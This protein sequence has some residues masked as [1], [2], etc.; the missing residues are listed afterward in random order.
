MTA[1]KTGRRKKKEKIIISLLIYRLYNTAHGIFYCGRFERSEMVMRYTIIV[2]I[3]MHSRGVSSIKGIP[4]VVQ[5]NTIANILYY[6][7]L[8]RYIVNLHLCKR[9]D[10]RVLLRT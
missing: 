4:R 6:F 2:I 10:G 1:T 5:R 7:H 8:Y 9:P 3:I